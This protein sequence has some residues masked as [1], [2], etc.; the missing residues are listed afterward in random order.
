MMLI[1]WRMAEIPTF[2]CILTHY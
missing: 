2:R 1:N